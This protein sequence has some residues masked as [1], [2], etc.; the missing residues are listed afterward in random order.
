MAV[1]CTIFCLFCY[2]LLS[3]LTMPYTPY[4]SFNAYELPIESGAITIKV[5]LNIVN[6]NTGSTFI[7]CYNK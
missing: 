4:L 5:K 1:S 7:I 6:S 3:S 2:I